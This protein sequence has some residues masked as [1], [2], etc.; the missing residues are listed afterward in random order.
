MASMY[1][2]REC[3]EVLLKHKAKHL[4]N[5]MGQYPVMLAAMKMNIECLKVLL[6]QKKVADG[7]ML[8]NYGNYNALHH[9]CIK[10]YKTTEKAITVAL[11]ASELW[12]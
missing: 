11:S 5:G 1:G 12:Y 9:L 6:T 3:I 8:E 7:K 10:T 2:R 4:P